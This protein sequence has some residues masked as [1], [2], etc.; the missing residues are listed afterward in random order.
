LTSTLSADDRRGDPA[1][2]PIQPVE[3]A[4]LA[5]DRFGEVLSGAQQEQL[6]D[7]IAR[8]RALLDG[9]VVWNI[10]STAHGG[11]VA[12]MLHSLLAYSRAGGIDTRWLVIGGEPDFFRVT[13]RLHNRLHGNPGDGG[14]LGDLER[15]I[16]AAATAG[17]ASQIAALV[18]PGDVVLLH[19]PQTA[20]L[21]KP[22]TGLGAYVIWR[23]H[24]G[25]DVP[26]DLARQAWAFLLPFVSAAA[27]QVFSR[28]SY[29][30]EGL[31]PTRVR[32]IQPSIDPFSAKNE[33]LEP[34]AVKG[35]LAASGVVD[36][37]SDVEVASF[38]RRDGSPGRVDRRAEIVGGPL[39]LE[40]PVVAQVSRWDRL[41]DPVGVMDGFVAG[42]ASASSAH[43]VLAGPQTSAVS[44]DPE[45][46]G[47]LAECV[48]RREKLAP[49]V[50]PRIHLVMLPMAD[51]EENAVMVNALQR[52]AAVVVQKSLAEGFGLTVAEAMWKSRPVVGSAVGGILDQIVDGESGVLVDPT[53][54]EGFGLAVCGLL[55]DPDGARGIGSNARER[56]REH[57]LAIRHLSEYVDL[58]EVVVGKSEESSGPG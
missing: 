50:R 48:A 7:A 33:A 30:W 38:L 57:F 36:G 20:G 10:N 46:A 45:G 22:L 2:T 21:A 5:L 12:E 28:E 52:W 47:V 25:I 56:V 23:A 41:K 8:G 42:V 32:V 37:G 15:Q 54:V 35:I 16:Y 34:D 3:I 29:V 40:V 6:R 49:E 13:K 18:R 26:N 39:P 14:P 51:A 1:P 58:L 44:D 17:A 9:R 4:P 27:A 53:D 55:N 24:I 11:G 43:L 19:D 31:D